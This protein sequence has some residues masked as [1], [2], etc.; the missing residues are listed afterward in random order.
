MINK[1]M[2]KKVVVLAADGDA[3]RIFSYAEGRF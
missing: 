2:A 1:L 3:V